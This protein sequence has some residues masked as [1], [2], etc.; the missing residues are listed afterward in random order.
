MKHFL[1]FLLFFI[2]LS[3]QY[4]T[5]KAQSGKRN[6][7]LQQI[8]T[9]NF[10][11]SFDSIATIV[12]TT[13][14]LAKNQPYTADELFRLQVAYDAAV[15]PLN[16]LLVGIKNDLLNAKKIKLILADPQV[17]GDS[18]QL[19][20]QEAYKNYQNTFVPL[21]NQLEAQHKI[22]VLPIPMLISV[23]NSAFE[24]FKVLRGLRNEMKKLTEQLINE[25]LIAPHAVLSW[26]QLGKN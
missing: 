8:S 5:V 15:A 17:Y 18:Y 14:A 10:M 1:F 23:I 3:S 21:K 6:A 20:L 9:A 19:R 24:L 2:A 11:V 7:A 16:N 4:A 25:Q 22:D 12:E 26:E 13:G